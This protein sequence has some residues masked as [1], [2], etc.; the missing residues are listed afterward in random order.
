[1]A[2][3]VQ[4]DSSTQITTQVPANAFTGKISVTTPTGT[5]TATTNS[6]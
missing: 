3:C 6:W 4:V 1:V 2:T 5:T